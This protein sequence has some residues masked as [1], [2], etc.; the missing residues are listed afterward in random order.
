M[1]KYWYNSSTGE[2]TAS[3]TPPWSAEVAMGPYDSEELAK[4]AYLVSDAR[5]ADFDEAEREWKGADTWDEEER[6]WKQNW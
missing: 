5:N 3:D 1:S 2:V 6:D 4:N